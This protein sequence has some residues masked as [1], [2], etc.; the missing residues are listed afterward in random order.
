MAN[1]ENPGSRRDSTINIL[2]PIKFLPFQ[3]TLFTIPD[4]AE[5]VF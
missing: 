5:I 2:I 3:T 4:V 1:K